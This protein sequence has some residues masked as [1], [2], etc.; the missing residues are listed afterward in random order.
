MHKRDYQEHIESKNYRMRQQIQSSTSVIQTSQI[1]SR[2]GL[3]QVLEFLK[4]ALP[5]AVFGYQF[6]DWWSQTDYYKQSK[7]KPIPPPPSQILV[8]FL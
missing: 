1:Y 8:S 4:T 5:V 6:W 7:L 3:V 2:W